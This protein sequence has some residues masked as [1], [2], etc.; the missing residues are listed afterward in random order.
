MLIDL[1]DFWCGG[2]ILLGLHLHLK[3][4]IVE[5]GSICAPSPSIRPFYR[6]IGDGLGGPNAAIANFSCSPSKIESP[7]QRLA[8]DIN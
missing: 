5:L 1:A 8:R 3:L 2:S 7:Y 6:Y 4:A